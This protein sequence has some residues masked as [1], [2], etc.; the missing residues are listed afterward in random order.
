MPTR[1]SALTSHSV[2]SVVAESFSARPRPL[3]GVELEWPVHRSGDA[4][5]RPTHGELLAATTQPLP[6]GGRVTIEPGGQVELSTLP[7]GT[8]DGALDAATRD[9]AV[10]HQLL[11][12]AG[13]AATDRAVDTHRAPLR[14]L[15]APRYHCMEQFF[16]A[17]GEAGRWMMCN[18]ASLQV[19][20]GH[21]PVDADRRWALTYRLGPALIATFANSPGFDVTGRRWESMRQAIWWS[22][23]PGRTR[24]PRTGR[25]ARQAWLDYALD[26]D[27]ILMR[28][29]DGGN[30]IP[31]PPGFTFGRWL[32][33]GHP[34][35][36]PTAEDLRYHLTTLFPPVRPR[37]WLEL[38]MLD[39]LPARL[40]DVATVV[41][42]AALTTDAAVELE[43]RM[44]STEDL[45]CAAARYGMGHPV[46]ASAARLL[47][48]VIAP[49]VA[50]VTADALRREDV[51]AFRELFVERGMSPA[52]MIP[53][54]DLAAGLRPSLAP[55]AAPGTALAV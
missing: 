51:T 17:G 5:A 52:Q 19:N 13:L 39:L 27:V 25:P 29:P 6:H 54:N 23:D 7:V 50:T 22:I 4:G 38:R 49:A 33:D 42:L 41:V 34:L 37:G 11:A 46:L 55:L 40:R 48:D 16:T 45:W 9:A 12:A 21:D 14:I 2:A 8:P 20:L 36:W 15:D 35:G 53:D 32:T 18:T 1:H 28:S 3:Y 43:E 26:A 30:A 10:L 44:P 31:I 24:P 47:F